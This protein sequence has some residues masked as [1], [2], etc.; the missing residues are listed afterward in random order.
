[1]HWRRW[2]DICLPTD[3]GGLGFRRLEDVVQAFSLKL[4]WLFRSQQSLWAQFLL[5]KYCRSNHPILAPILH[6]ASVVWRRLK[7]VGLIAELHIAWQL[8]QG[9]IFFW[10]DCWMGDMTLAQM[11]PY[12]EHTSVQVVEFFDD[13]G[14]DIDKLLLVRLHYMAVQVESL[15]LCPDVLDRSMWKDTPDGRFSTKSA[16]QLVRTGSTLQAYCRMI[17]CPIIP[18]TISFFC[19]RL[20]HGLVSVDVIIQKRIRAHMASRCQCCSE[21]ETIQH[22]FIDSTVAHQTATPSNLVEAVAPSQK[23]H[24]QALQQIK[25]RHAGAAAPFSSAYAGATVLPSSTGGVTVSSFLVAPVGTTVQSP[26]FSSNPSQQL[27]RSKNP[28]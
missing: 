19:W 9:C 1:M 2:K 11:F 14:W 21:I 28:N 17:W 7:G 15:P 13:T 27:A 4:W 10:H 5:G 24:R 20:W 25:Q 12:R 8:G 16:W 18:Q 22:V 3:E 6:S 23:Q 26:F